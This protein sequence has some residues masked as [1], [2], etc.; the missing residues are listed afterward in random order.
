MEASSGPLIPGAAS[1]SKS[2]SRVGIHPLQ[3]CGPFGLLQRITLVL[4][5]L[6]VHKTPLV[7]RV[8]EPIPDV[9]WKAGRSPLPRAGHK[10]LTNRLAQPSC[11]TASI[12]REFRRATLG[13]CPQPGRPRMARR[14]LVF[15]AAD[16]PCEVGCSHQIDICRYLEHPPSRS[17]T[18]WS[19]HALSS[20]S[21]SYERIVAP[22]TD[23][24]HGTSPHAS[25]E[26]ASRYLLRMPAR[27]WTLH[28]VEPNIGLA[29]SCGQRTV[30]RP[31]T[32]TIGGESCCTR[33]TV[34]GAGAPG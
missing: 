18:T 15:P 2:N 4:T 3:G 13:V 17:P 10:P 12:G 21:H 16:V 29:P 5:L 24:H 1:H 33:R 28:R 6:A 26:G 22:D 8:I 9:A 23:S 11:R 25:R 27:T 32:R 14:V 34:R 7:H 19:A 31:R 20:V 30:T